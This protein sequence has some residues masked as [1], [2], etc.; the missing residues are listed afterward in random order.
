MIC[1]VWRRVIINSEFDLV[2]SYI[3]HYETFS[4]RRRS[5]MLLV[6]RIVRFLLGSV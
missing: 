1:P 5:L 2:R 3:G 4:E 6:W